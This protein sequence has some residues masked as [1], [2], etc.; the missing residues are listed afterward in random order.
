M[1]S[2][3]VTASVLLL[4]FFDFFGFTQLSAVCRVILAVIGLSCNPP[5][6]PEQVTTKEVIE[7]Y[8]TTDKSGHTI[9]LVSP[10]SVPFLLFFAFFLASDM[11]IWWLGGW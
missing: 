10:T 9:T 11:L 2:P 5:K 4:S 8:Q 1:V 7:E 6:L 3:S